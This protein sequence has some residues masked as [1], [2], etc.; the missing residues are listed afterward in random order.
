MYVRSWVA[1]WVCTGLAVAVST[2]R[3][4]EH[5]DDAVGPGHPIRRISTSLVERQNLTIRLS[6]RRFTRLI[7]AFS[8]KLEN[9]TAAVSLHFMYY[10][11]AR[12]HQTLA[13]RADGGQDDARDD[14]RG[15]GSRVVTV[16]NRRSAGFCMTVQTDPP[17]KAEIPYRLLIIID[18]CRN[19][20]SRHYGEFRQP[21]QVN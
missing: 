6:M 5:N 10:N 1:V 21:C 11:F 14:G 19:A 9:L 20:Q 4:P 12:P 17:P 16:R 13:K 3:E 18:S 2:T 8:K 15:C 7:N